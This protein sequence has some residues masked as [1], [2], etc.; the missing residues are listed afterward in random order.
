MQ[1]FLKAMLLLQGA[2]GDF[3]DIGL[4]KPLKAAIDKNM[5]EAP[6]PHVD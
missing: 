1:Q 5:Q 6:Y 4:L 3:V 2:C